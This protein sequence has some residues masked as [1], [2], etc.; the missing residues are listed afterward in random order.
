[1]DNSKSMKSP[2]EELH[3]HR[4]LGHSTND[5]S[6]TEFEWSILRF[7][8]AFERCIVQMS[9]MSGGHV[10]NVQEIILLHVVSMQK[11]PQTSSSLSRQLNRDDVANVQYTLRKLAS[12]NLIE[13]NKAKGGKLFTFDIT[14]A[15]SQLVKEYSKVRELLLTEKTKFID[16]VDQKLDDSR[17]VISFLTGVYDE[18]AREVPIYTSPK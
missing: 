3:E 16:N 15:G 7:M 18:V 14:A 11:M 5:I 10:L 17:R 8:T 4:E 6:I 1:M 12:I 9:N 2:N 13:K